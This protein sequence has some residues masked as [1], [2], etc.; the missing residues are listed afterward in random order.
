MCAELL[1]F[2]QGQINLHIRSPLPDPG[3]DTSATLKVRAVDGRVVESRLYHSCN[4][5]VLPKAL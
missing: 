3:I 5:R 2:D 4:A 1:A